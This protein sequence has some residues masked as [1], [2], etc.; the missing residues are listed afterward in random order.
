[1]LKAFSATNE[2]PLFSIV[3]GEGESKRQISQ[4][5]SK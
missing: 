3:L 2:I 5:I 4:N 1:M